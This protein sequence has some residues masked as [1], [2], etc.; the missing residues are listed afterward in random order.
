M[1]RATIRAHHTATS[2]RPWN[3]SHA[4]AELKDAG[5]QVLRRA[6]AWADPDGD[7]GNKSTYKFIHHEVRDG[8]VGPANVRA[9]ISGIGVLNGGR[10]GADIPSRDRGRVYAHLA[11]HLRDAGHDPAPLKK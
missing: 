8:K 9:C 7:P 11:A 3:G 5:P 4:E 2:D 6:Y 1:A 10:G